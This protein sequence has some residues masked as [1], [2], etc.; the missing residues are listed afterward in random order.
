M[1]ST[2]LQLRTKVQV[3][4][5]LEQEEFVTADE[6]TGYFNE[7]IRIATAEQLSWNSSYFRSYGNLDLVAGQEEYDLPADIYELKILGIYHSTGANSVPRPMPTSEKPASSGLPAAVR[8]CT[9]MPV[10]LK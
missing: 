5:D 1:A 6:L 4:L 3:D 8:S 10:G 7:A 9:R 2:L